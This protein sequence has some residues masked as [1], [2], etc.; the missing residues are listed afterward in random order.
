VVLVAHG[1]AARIDDQAIGVPTD[2]AVVAIVDSIVLDHK[3]TF[4][5]SG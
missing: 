3:T 2:A 1:S 5:K 4:R